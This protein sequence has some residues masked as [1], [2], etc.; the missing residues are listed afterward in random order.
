M[1]GGTQAVRVTQAYVTDGIGQGTAAAKRRVVRLVLVMGQALIDQTALAGLRGKRHHGVVAEHD[2]PA[3]VLGGHSCAGLGHERVGLRHHDI[4][5]TERIGGE[6]ILQRLVVVMGHGREGGLLVLLNGLHGR[7][8][9][10][11]QGRRPEHGVVETT[12]GGTQPRTFGT[13]RKAGAPLHHPSRG[14]LLGGRECYIVQEIIHEV[15]CQSII[16][17]HC[18]SHISQPRQLHGTRFVYRGGQARWTAVQHGRKWSVIVLH[19]IELGACQNGGQ[20]AAYRTGV[21]IRPGAKIRPGVQLIT[22]AGRWAPW[23]LGELGRAVLA[24]LLGRLQGRLFLSR[25]PSALGVLVA[26]VHGHGASARCLAHF[27]AIWIDHPPGALPGAL[28]LHPDEAAVERQVVPDGVLRE[29]KKRKRQ[30]QHFFC[31]PKTSTT[32]PTSHEDHIGKNNGPCRTSPWVSW[33]VDQAM[34]SFAMR[35]IRITPVPQQLATCPPL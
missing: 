1:F 27:S 17:I 26:V 12:R 2:V 3:G 16:Q 33:V 25:P 35:G 13:I 21:G 30:G 34:P 32:K 10:G 11:V 22:A 15:I 18:P 6:Q 31:Y 24:C 29:R 19:I 5:V 9:E 14:R 8:A 4:A 7:L 23:P 28:V 20:A